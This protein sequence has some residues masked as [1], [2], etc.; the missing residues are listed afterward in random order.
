[1]FFLFLLPCILVNKDVYINYYRKNLPLT[2]MASDTVWPK[3][4][5][6]ASHAAHQWLTASMRMKQTDRQTDGRT[7]D[8]YVTLSA[9]RGQRHNVNV[10]IKIWF[11]ATGWRKITANITQTCTQVFA[12][13][14]GCRCP[15][16]LFWVNHK[17]QTGL[18]SRGI[19]P[20]ISHLRGD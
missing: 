9:R 20:D 19:P 11:L 14:R 2:S 16:D 4:T 15:V 13:E 8:H 1:M 17:G 5:L 6:A 12:F 7:P 18:H 3:C 10:K